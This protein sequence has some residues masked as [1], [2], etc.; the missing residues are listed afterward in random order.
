MT[1][2]G[3]ED[4]AVFLASFPAIQS[5]IKVHGHTD[6]MRIQLDVP[7]SELGEAVK[8]LAWRECL[9]RVTIEPEE[10]DSKQQSNSRKIHI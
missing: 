3:D 1:S 8:L 2:S 9:L 7:E 4:K 5:A 10:N 6:G